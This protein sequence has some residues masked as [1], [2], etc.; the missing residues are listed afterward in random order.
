MN[1]I[2][3][4]FSLNK[5]YQSVEEFCNNLLVSF[6]PITN[7]SKELNLPV[8]K[9]TTFFDCNVTEEMKLADIIKIKGN[10]YI[11]KLKII[12][13]SLYSDEPFWDINPKSDP[14]SNYFCEWTN[15]VPNCFTE[16]Y[17]RGAGIISFRHPNF[18]NNI[19]ELQKNQQNCEISNFVDYMFF[20]K[21]AYEKNLLSDI[22]YIEKVFPRTEVEFFEVGGQKRLS[23]FFENSNFLSTDRI[24]IT[25]DLITMIRK[26]KRNE[27]LGRF[28]KPLNEHICEFRTSIS[29]N[30]EIRIPY[31][32]INNKLVFLFGFIK[33]VQKTTQRIINN[34]ND[35]RRIYIA[36][37]QRQL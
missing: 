30:R 32:K 1:L 10:P 6:I 9:K 23:D 18:A 8:S 29:S 26:H 16:A 4:E 7:L 14:Q 36:I 27:S 21:H 31:F 35:C 13:A 25:E 17:E 37:N 20:L 24:T 12:I 33:K 15:D 19:I 2:I 22:L 11:S 34:A 5:Q 28:S 3:N